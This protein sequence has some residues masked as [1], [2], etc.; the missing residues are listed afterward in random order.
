MKQV[1]MIKT[2]EEDEPVERPKSVIE[3]EDDELGKQLKNSDYLQC[4]CFHLLHLLHV[5]AS[6]SMD[7]ALMALKY[8]STQT[9][10]STFYLFME[11]LFFS[12]IFIFYIF[13]FSVISSLKMS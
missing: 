7:H 11:L 8:S 5:S 10:L 13:V 3:I 9:T 4:L 1:S 2:Q 12:L 6:Y